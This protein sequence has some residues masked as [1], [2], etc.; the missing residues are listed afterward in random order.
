MLLEQLK[1]LGFTKNESN[2]YLA[3]FRVG[4]MKA[5]Q[6]MKET[7]LPRSVVYL[8]LQELL[9]RELISKIEK[10]GVAVFSANDPMNLVY[11][12]RMRATTAEEVA[13]ELKEYKGVANREATLYEGDD[14]IEK[15]A[16]KNLDASAGETIYFMGSSKFGI[17]ANLGRFWKKYHKLRAQ[18]KIKCK[19]LYD[20][21]TNDLILKDRNKSPLCEARYLPFGAENPM[22]FNICGDVVS[23]VVPGENPPIAFAIR[24]KETAKSLV[25]YFEYLWEQ[26]KDVL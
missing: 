9:G 2:V 17:Q 26:S 16:E 5:G 15:V 7:S 19:I 20:R 1:H 13:K 18:K 8:A 11:E 6:I 21:E 10:N 23:I 25:N 14:V 24:S 4:K 3:L 12:T 22:W